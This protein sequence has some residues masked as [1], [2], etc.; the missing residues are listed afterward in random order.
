MRH[1]SV[2]NEPI[3]PADSRQAPCP[4]LDPAATHTRPTSVSAIERPGGAH[5]RLVVIQHWHT[6]LS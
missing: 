5:A 6:P 2:A 3:L 4:P 1:D